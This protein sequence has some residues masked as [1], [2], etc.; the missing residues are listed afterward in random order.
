[1]SCKGAKTSCMTSKSII[2][3]GRCGFPRKAY[4]ICGGSTRSSCSFRTGGYGKG[5]GGG[6][7]LGRGCGFGGGYG[8][9]KGSGF[10]GRS[11]FSGG[12][13]FGGGCG[14]GGR[15]GFSGGCEFVGVFGH[16]G[17]S[18]FG[19]GSSFGGGYGGFVGGEKATLQNLND[20]LASY[21]D[22]VR[23]LESANA[24]LERQIREYYERKAAI[25]Q[26]DYTHYL[27]EI[28]DLQNKI[29]IATTENANLL[30]QIDNSKLAADDFR[31]KYEHEVVMRQYVE[32]DIANLRRL[33]DQTNMAKCE[34][35]MQLRSL[36]DELACM[37]KNHQE[38]LCALRAQLTGTVNVEVDA[39][40]QE[41]LKK[42]L[43]EIRAHYENIIQR[44]RREQ[45]E[46]FNDQMAGLNK[47]ME[48][49]T[50]DMAK[51]RTEITDLRTTLKS[52]EI[53]LQSQISMVAALEKSLMETEASYSSMLAC[54]QNQINMLEA[55]LAQLRASIEQQGRDYAVLLDIKTRLEQEIATYRCLLEKQDIK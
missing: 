21:L 47:E 22:M 1:M 46:W 3:K 12:S 18:G 9:G 24:V 11:G 27:C 36:E 52:L 37:H 38:E 48:K 25:P 33:L 15:S 8:L 35:E 26:R 7:G 31:T 16:G 54:F 51:Y 50:E 23:S 32:A 49:S 53:E 17:G 30:L 4:S 13:I 29:T 41:D 45:E 5:F 10:G 14:F 20:R 55:E 44:H 28:K 40:P 43:Q 6:H 2:S 39:A 42:V 19:G 34:L